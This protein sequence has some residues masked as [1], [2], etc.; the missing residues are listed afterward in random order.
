VGVEAHTLA[1]GGGDAGG[2]AA[3]GDDAA[4]G[5]GA[6]GTEHGGGG[7]GSHGSHLVW[8]VEVGNSKGQTPGQGSRRYITR[9]SGQWRGRRDA[10]TLNNPH[11]TTTASSAPQRSERRR[12]HSKL[13]WG[14]CFLAEHCRWMDGGVWCGERER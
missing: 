5:H 8:C 2:G 6:A 11:A 3:R 9:C 13:R 10:G 14:L 4:V 1:A 12:R 7:K